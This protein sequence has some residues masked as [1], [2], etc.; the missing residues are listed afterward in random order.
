[1][2]V[3]FREDQSWTHKDNAPEN[4]ATLRKIA[5]QALKQVNDRQSFKSRR[6]IAGWNDEYLIQILQNMRF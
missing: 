4:M 1:L 6:K 3:S 2:D 5:L